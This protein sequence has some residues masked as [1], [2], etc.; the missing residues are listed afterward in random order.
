MRIVKLVI[1]MMLLLSCAVAAVRFYF[2][3]QTLTYIL[4]K[5]GAENVLVQGVDV[6][7]DRLNVAELGAVFDLPAGGRI[8][9]E[10]NNIS[11]NYNL[12]Q[13]LNTAKFEKCRVEQLSVTLWHKGGQK[14]ALPIQL[15]MRI[16][17]VKEHLRSRI[18]V[19]EIL[20]RKLQL[21]GD[22]SPHL[23]GKSIRITAAVEEHL[24]R[25]ELSLALS[26]GKSITVIL[27]SPDAYHGT[28]KVILQKTGGPKFEADVSLLPE[29]I[30][31]KT[32]LDLATLKE[33]VV[34]GDSDLLAGASRGLLTTTVTVP[35]AAAEKKEVE[36]VA[37][38]KDAVV[39]GFDVSS[40]RLQLAGK[41]EN[42]SLYLNESSFV[43]AVK[44]ET[45]QLTLGRLNVGLRGVVSQSD[46]QQQLLF[47]DQQ[48]F[49][50][51]NLLMGEFRVK[52]LDFCVARPLQIS[53]GEGRWEVADNTFNCTPFSIFGRG[54]FADIGPA[55]CT[56][57]GVRSS[58]GETGIGAELQV[59]D[60]FFSN[61]QQGLAV[62]DISAILTY[63]ENQVRG[64]VLFTPQKMDSWLQLKGQHDLVTGRGSVIF[65]TEE[66][67]EFVEGESGLS[68]LLAHWD[69]PGNL[70]GGSLD[71]RLTGDWDRSG[72]RSAVLQAGIRGGSGYYQNL[73]FKGLELHQ[74]ISLFPVL[75]SNRSGS[76]FL[77]RLIGGVDVTAIRASID[78]LPSQV[79]P[80]PVLQI[81]ELDAGLFAGRVNSPEICYDLNQP[82]STFVVNLANIDLETIVDLIKMD[83]LHVTG[84]VSGSIPVAV[85]GREVT[86]EGGELY[87]ES[88]G[89][90]IRYTPAGAGQTGVTG[91]ALLAVENL[92]YSTLTATAGYKASGQLDLDISLLGKSP[93]LDTIRPVQLNIHAEQN[94]PALLQS[95]RF[96][97]GLTD[98]LDKRLKQHYN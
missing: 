53:F 74:D 83:S 32:D 6:G 37:V 78:L 56:F 2:L 59:S 28:A 57:S 4:Q 40:V 52:K 46:G 43:E 90:V 84:K 86:V 25:A 3:D 17:L 45:E 93:G 33:F 48:K 39:S 31:V 94:L 15:P 30:L 42:G 67:L 54:A 82:D 10:L 13:L 14:L 70:E 8:A 72:L 35:W 63:K 69:Y 80:L 79:G 96:S 16:A 64:R 98:E 66:T 9:V 5:A 77:E 76:F 22:I 27:Q 50:L 21:H 91:Y 11:F 19:K 18:P 68:A 36:F 88:P 41:L 75:A 60:A 61:E 81:D 7:L 97:K 1:V 92:Q 51:E 73:L 62:K 12:P 20:V 95:L 26:L 71:F 38:L 58:F 65:E 85:K 24:I 49:I 34:F 55:S 23:R 29:T 87:S 89:G 44:I 47:F